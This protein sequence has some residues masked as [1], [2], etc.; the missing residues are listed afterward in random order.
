MAGIAVLCQAQMQQSS[1]DC[2]APSSERC[3]PPHGMHQPAAGGLPPPP[4]AKDTS[5]RTGDFSSLT[6][7]SRSE[8]CVWECA[9]YL[10]IMTV[11]NVLFLRWLL[12][13]Q[14]NRL[15]HSSCEGP[16]Q[17][18]PQSCQHTFSLFSFPTSPSLPT[19]LYLNSSNSQ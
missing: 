16:S 12:R 3:L 7:I 5:C 6:V 17:L 2:Q 10:K 18:P 13:L 11:V 9:V 8:N 14:G 1:P 19:P 4:A 15:H